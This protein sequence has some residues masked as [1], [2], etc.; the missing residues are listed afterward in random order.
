[1]E[2][3]Q[4]SCRGDAH[5]LSKLSSPVGLTDLEDQ[6][7]AGEFHA[8]LRHGLFE[9]VNLHDAKVIG[10]NAA[11]RQPQLQLTVLSVVT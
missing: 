6:T 1:M 11:C 4:G 10:L 7:L 5:V 3:R 8:L 9:V 2:I